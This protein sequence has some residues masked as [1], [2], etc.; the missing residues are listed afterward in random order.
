[1]SLADI[2]TEAWAILALVTAFVGITLIV[3]SILRLLSRGVR[4]YEEKYVIGATKTLDAMYLTITR[5]QVLYLSLLSA[6]VVFILVSVSISSVILGGV[7]GAL[8]F[9]TPIVAIRVLKWRRDLKFGEQLVDGLIAMGNA[10]RVGRSLTDGFNLLAAEMDNPMGQEMR[11]LTQEIRLGVSLEDALNHLHER[12]PGEDLD[13]LITSILISR[14]VGG[15]LAEIFDNIA[16]TIRDR[17]RIEGK[18]R[19]L[20]AQ[21]KLQGAIIAILPV[22][23]G[24]FLNAWSPRLMRPMF[25]DWLGL[26]MLAAIVIMELIGCY[27]IWRIVS[28]KV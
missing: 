16:D 18:I 11:L 6:L 22:I 27:M 5:Q 8:A 2:R 26:A 25:T 9:L 14:E 21:G 19:S 28:I 15:N 4:S 10:L 12:M 17:H 1:M 24:V 3:F 20:T 23:I 13:I 7:L